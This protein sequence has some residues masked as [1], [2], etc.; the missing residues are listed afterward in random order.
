MNQDFLA[1]VGQGR[2]ADRTQE[3]LGAS[4][5]GIVA[6]RRRFFE[7]LEHIALGGEAK[8]IIRD[9]AK[10]VK[11]KLPMMDRDKV[12]GSLTRE[13]ILSNP[14]AELMCTSYIFQA[15]QPDAVRKAV[16]LAMGL[17]AKEF[18]GIV[19]SRNST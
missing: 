14:R 7:E 10:N 5:R 16:S 8:G 11:V 4:D 17:D 3:H 13:Q 12:L 15:G 1:W 18:N 19:Q 9:P 6:V 2:I